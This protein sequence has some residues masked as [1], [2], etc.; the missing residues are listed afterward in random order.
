VASNSEVDDHGPVIDALVFDFDGLILDTET[1]LFEAW[2]RTY[3]HFGVEPISLEQWVRSLGLPSNDP[4]HLDRRALLEERLGRRLDEADTTEIQRRMREQ[5]LDQQPL[6]PGVMALLDTADRRGL[7]LAVASSSPSDWVQGHLERRGLLDRF[8]HF[9][10][11]GAVLA[12]KPDPATYL[13]A[14]ANLGVDPSRAVAFE[15]SP[16]GVHAAKAAGLF[17]IACPNPVSAALDFEHADVV[18]ESLAAVDL[19]QLAG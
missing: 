6:L 18:V 4:G 1:P 3:L 19:D 17:A 5:M 2:R 11:A 7:P 10:C 15:D 16:H 9:S 12:G 14:C 8:R 13:D